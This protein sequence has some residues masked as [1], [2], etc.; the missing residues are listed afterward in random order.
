MRTLSNRLS[1]EFGKGFSVTALKYMRFFYFTYPELIE[2]RH[3]VRGE[4]DNKLPAN[5]LQIG[6][7]LRDVFA[8]A[9][10]DTWGNGVREWGQT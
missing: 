5:A 9:E 6:H 10:D 3:A 4:F 1:A 2:I 8:L 7:A